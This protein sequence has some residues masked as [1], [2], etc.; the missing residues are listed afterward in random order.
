MTWWEILLCCPPPKLLWIELQ[1]LNICW[2]TRLILSTDPSWRERCWYQS[3]NLK[4]KFKHFSKPSKNF[5]F[6]HFYIV[7]SLFCVLCV[8]NWV[9]HSKVCISKIEF[10]FFSLQKISLYWFS[11]LSSLIQ[12][13][14]HPQYSKKL[15]LSQ[16]FTYLRFEK[17]IQNFKLLREFLFIILFCHGETP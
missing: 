1:F 14:I 4:R 16:S 13:T 8:R 17:K 7:M 2:M 15:L 6:S 5:K 3:Q 9:K 10:T 11:K 12:R